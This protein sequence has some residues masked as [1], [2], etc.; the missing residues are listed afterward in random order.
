M[1]DCNSW[2]V[3]K[4]E[5]V[6]LEGLCERDHSFLIGL[7][8][9]PIHIEIGYTLSLCTWRGNTVILHYHTLIGEFSFDHRLLVLCLDLK[10]D[11]IWEEKRTKWPEDI[12]IPEE[13]KS[14]CTY[15]VSVQ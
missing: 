11:Q 8:V 15:K 13:V 1:K 6:D 12:G 3:V 2:A 9:V 4:V 7:S 10:Q 5:T 14:K